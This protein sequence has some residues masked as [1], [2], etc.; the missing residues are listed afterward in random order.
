[1]KYDVPIPISKYLDEKE[2]ILWTQGNTS[3]YKGMN[4][5]EMND[6][7]HSI[8]SKFSEWY[9]HNRLEIS[10]ELIKKLTTEY[11]LDTVKETIHKEI[12]K[13][14]I[15]AYDIDPQTVCTL[16]DS[17]Y[18][19]SSFSKLYEIN[20]ET[21]KKDFAAAMEIVSNIGTTISYEL[22][23]P[24]E[25]TMV[26]ACSVQSDTIIWKVD[27]MRLLFDDYTFTAEYRVVNVWAFVV[28]GLVL[29]L[30]VGSGVGLWRRR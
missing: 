23:I 26:D 22:V 2:Q 11:R 18:V 28:G 9:G 5:Y 16:L 29:I 21:L 25:L 1:L 6:Y 4:G 8:N 27:G 14:E 13:K 15:E 12:R 19:T 24:G 3:D 30:A 10:F 17:F 7:L 20:K